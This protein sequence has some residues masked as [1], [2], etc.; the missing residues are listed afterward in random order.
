MKKYIFLLMG[1]MFINGNVVL[2]D[3]VKPTENKDEV[4]TTVEKKDHQSEITTNGVE[5]P[6]SLTEKQKETTKEPEVKKESTLQGWVRDQKGT[7]YFYKED[8]TMAISTWEGDYY[9]ES[10]GKMATSKWV[11]GARYYVDSTGKWIPD[12]VKV[13]GWKQQGNGWYF[14]DEQEKLVTNQW[15]QTYYYVGND[16]RM[17]TSSWVDGDKYY[18]SE[19]GEWIPG[20][21][22]G[23]DGWDQ[24]KNGTWHYYRNGIPVLNQWVGDYY[25]LNN[26]KMATNTWVDN[27]RY[28]VGNDGTWIETPSWSED[29]KHLV[30]ELARAYID[31]E[32]YDSW[33]ERLVQ[34]YN[35]GMRSYSGYYIH[36][37]DDWCDVFVSS[38]F[39]MAGVIDL[40]QKEAYVP[41]HIHLFKNQGIWIGKSTPQAG[42]I[43]TFDWNGDGVADHIAIVEKVLSDRIVTLEGNT[44]VKGGDGSKVMRK[45]HEIDSS[46]IF[47]YARPQYQ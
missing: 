32:Q 33:Q 40:I 36:T 41:F 27:A 13:S 45:T 2:A 42:D 44:D 35:T 24:E 14:Y 21:V 3:E 6:K 46:D 9:L 43:V 23:K 38:I 31:T 28:Y 39:Q 25:L 19:T 29:Q 12:K 37:W 8:H 4:T 22:K 1:L 7:W 34:V 17:V 20:V 30:L 11:D 10:D 26:G 16:G 15:V 47:G 5:K 18:V